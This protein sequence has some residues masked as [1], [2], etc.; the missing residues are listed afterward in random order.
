MSRLIDADVLYQVEKLLD[1][2]IVRQDKIAS[3]LLKQ[4]LYD[5]QYFPTFTPQNEVLTCEGCYWDSVGR[6]FG[7]C[8]FCAREK[9]DNYSHSPERHGEDTGR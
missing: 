7:K 5:I 9:A 1:T 3:E 2:N 4:V 8:G 6:P